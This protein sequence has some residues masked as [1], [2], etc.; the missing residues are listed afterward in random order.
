[1]DAV[2]IVVLISGNGSNLQ[3]LIDATEAHVLPHTYIALVISNRSKAYGLERASLHQI[4]TR[5]ITLKSYKDRGL[6]RQEYD[7]DLADAVLEQRP[8][9]VVLAGFMHIVSPLFLGKCPNVINLHPALPGAFPGTNAIQR[10]YEAYLRGECDKTGVMV[11]WVVPEVDAG[12]VILKQE[13]DFIPEESLEALE[14]RIH[15]IEH[16][17]IVKATKMALQQL[18][19][20]PTSPTSISMAHSTLLNHGDLHQLRQMAR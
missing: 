11:H 2:R 13:I 6:S 17:V 14:T 8:D 18:G 3:A 5:I 15:T 9:L 7:N 19:K 20:I 12:D 1:M 16:Q 4:P 10:A